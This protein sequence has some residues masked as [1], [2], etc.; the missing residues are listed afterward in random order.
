MVWSAGHDDDVSQACCCSKLL[1]LYETYQTIGLSQVILVGH[2]AGGWLGRA[3]MAD[4]MYFESPSEDPG[5]PHQGVA[6]LVTLGTPHIAPAAELARDMTGGALS[7]VNRT[8]PGKRSKDSRVL[9]A[10]AV[11]A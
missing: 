1:R 5:A 6:H 2:S 9:A 8:Y 3:F 11:H 10:F 7:W 4:P